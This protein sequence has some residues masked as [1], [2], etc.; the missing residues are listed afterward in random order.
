MSPLTH[1]WGRV[2]VLLLTIAAGLAAACDEGT[3]IPRRECVA[4]PTRAGEASLFILECSA[5][6]PASGEEIV[7]LVDACARVAE[8]WFCAPVTM[9]RTGLGYWNL[10]DGAALPGCP[11]Q[12]V[13]P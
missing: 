3:P 9:V 8:M 6:V 5:A 1:R 4:D 2:V 7:D 11:A 12:A 13:T 10:C